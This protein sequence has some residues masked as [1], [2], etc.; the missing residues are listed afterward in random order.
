MTELEE[1]Q[2][3]RTLAAKQKKE[4]EE[5]SRIIEERD[6]EINQQ[7]IQIENLIRALTN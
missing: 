7:D 5:Q 2:M 3:L 1:L 4:L 6:A